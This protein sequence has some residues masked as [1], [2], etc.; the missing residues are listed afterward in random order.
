MGAKWY[1]LLLQRLLWREIFKGE[2]NVSKSWCE[3][4]KL[5]HSQYFGSSKTWW[6]KRNGMPQYIHDH[7][8]INSFCLSGLFLLL[9]ICEWKV[10]L[11]LNYFFVFHI[12]DFDVY[13]KSVINCVFVR[14]YPRIFM[15]QCYISSGR[16]VWL[17]CLVYPTK[18]ATSNPLIYF[19]SKK[20]EV[21]RAPLPSMKVRKFSRRPTS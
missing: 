18:L 20:I 6:K 9:A 2:R 11:V 16:S 5:C 3:K 12:A 10:R 17:L 8:I 7:H 4:K 13:H 15:S 1:L 19:F 14:N 21:G